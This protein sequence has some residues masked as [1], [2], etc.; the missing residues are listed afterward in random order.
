M[1]VAVIFTC[2]ECKQKVRLRAQDLLRARRKPTHYNSVPITIMASSIQHEGCG[3]YLI[4]SAASGLV[5]D[6]RVVTNG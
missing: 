2:P 3:G 1:Q 5:L 6:G 4:K